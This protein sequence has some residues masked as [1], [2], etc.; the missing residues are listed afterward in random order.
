MN[1]SLRFVLAF[2]F[3]ATL[4][5]PAYEPIKPEPTRWSSAETIATGVALG[6]SEGILSRVT[7]HIWPLNW[8]LL[9]EIKS[10]IAQA[11]VNDAHRNGERVDH[12]LLKASSHLASWIAY[13]AAFNKI[14]INPVIIPHYIVVI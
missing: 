12:S 3:I 8:I 6:A 7:D 4:S 2:S 1:I 11:I 5:Y 14:E 13:M 9:S 10:L